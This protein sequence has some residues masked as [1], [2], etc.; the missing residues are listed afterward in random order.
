MRFA[1]DVRRQIA[2]IMEGETRWG[3]ATRA[4]DGESGASISHLCLDT[5]AHY[6]CG[7]CPRRVLLCGC[8]NEALENNSKTPSPGGKRSSSSTSAL[9]QCLLIG[10]ATRL[11]F[12][13]PRA[14]GYKTMGRS[15]TLAQLHPSTAEVALDEAGLLPKWVVYNELLSTSSVFL[16]KVCVVDDKW[17]DL[18]LP[19]LQNVDV[20][21]LSGGRLKEPEAPAAVAKAEGGAAKVVGGGERRNDDDAVAA[22]RQRYLARKAL[23]ASKQQKKRARN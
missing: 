6:V 21:R 15:A 12:R 7:I 5:H 13:L 14:N 10:L 18:L 8:T 1:R 23:V 19:K 22:A 2:R 3:D 11:A 4:R 20:K 17:V 9:R 16:S